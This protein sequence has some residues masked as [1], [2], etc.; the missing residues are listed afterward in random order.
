VAPWATGPAG[1]VPVAVT[2]I[3]SQFVDVTV[4]RQALVYVVPTELLAGNSAMAEAAP[5]VA[6]TAIFADPRRG[7][8]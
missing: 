6:R 1:D 2:L 7:C 5:T 3:C 4:F 8:P